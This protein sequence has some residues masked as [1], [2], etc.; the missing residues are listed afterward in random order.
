MF[1]LSPFAF[2]PSALRL[3]TDSNILG[4]DFSLSPPSML[5]IIF[6][7]GDRLKSVPLLMQ[8]ISISPLLEYDAQR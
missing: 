1:N 8:Q 2:R 5:R 4:T 6:V 3:G 7:F